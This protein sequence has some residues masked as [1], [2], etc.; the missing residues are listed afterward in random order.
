M[1]MTKPEDFGGGKVGNSSCVFCSD[2]DGSLKPR[3]VVREGMIK[4]WAERENLDQTTAE[5]FV[6]DYM[7]KMP[8]WK[9]DKL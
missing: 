7:A 9:K 2:E 3:N 8:A 5:K 1:A 6:D 4:F